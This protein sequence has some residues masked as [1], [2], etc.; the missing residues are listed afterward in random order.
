MV[1]FAVLLL[2][3]TQKMSK[4]V[5][6]TGI[7]S[8]ALYIFLSSGVIVLAQ[9]N[10]IKLPKMQFPTPG[11]Y[12]TVGYK[13]AGEL[14]KETSGLIEK[15]INPEEYVV[16]PGD[17]FFLYTDIPGSK[18]E[19]VPL[20]PDGRIV[21]AGVGAVNV[22]GMTLAQ[23]EQAVSGAVRRVFKATSVSLSLKKVRSFKVTVI[24]GVRK[25]GIVPASA[26]DRVSEVIDR[27]GGLMFNA[28][29]RRI[30]I[31]R[32]SLPPI[33]ADLQRYLAGELE[34]NPMLRGGDVI[35]VAVTSEKEVIEVWGEVGEPGK[36]EFRR[37]DSLFSALRFAKGLLVSSYLDS[38]EIVRFVQRGN[39]VERIFVTLPDNELERAEITARSSNIPLEI[40]DRIYVRA[41]PNWLQ[42]KTVVVTGEVRY[43]GRYAIYHDSTRI[44]EIIHRAG[45]LLESASLDNIQMIRRRDMFEV[46][47]EFRRL[48]G[49]PVAEMTEEELRY[50]KAR[51]REYPGI[52]SVDFRKVFAGNDEQRDIF[53]VE[54][55]SLHVP[56]KKNYINVLGKV[57][58][59]GRV[60][61]NPT[62]SYLD[63][64]ALAGGFGYRSDNDE[65]LIV[66]P[67]GE[68]TLASNSTLRIEPGDNILV[69]EKS[70]TKFIDVFTTA[71]TIATQL[72]TIGGIV[73]SVTRPK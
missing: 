15:E 46:D 60:L 45:G 30:T 35:N 61:Y 17:A 62:Y 13:M 21:I 28:S 49:V 44:S 50:F 70:D 72:I 9:P 12:D 16:G 37:G 69:P 55:D 29:L 54:N 63:Y 58:N 3:T 8:V 19:E 43:P 6:I 20:T 65:T 23:A 25:P 33:T 4:T 18:I 38:I 64:I 71:L 41:K 67:K 11:S 26:T 42:E 36:Y 5:G 22:R 32:D 10:T 57:V 39:D 7:V 48:Y 51:S 2:D 47:R 56:V 40:G 14:V 31:H 27:A 52:M 68:Q 24:G 66:K 59:P 34:Y 53:V 1:N 73:Y